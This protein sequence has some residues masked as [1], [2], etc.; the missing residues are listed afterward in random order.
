MSLTHFVSIDAS[1]TGSG[2]VPSSLSERLYM[3]HTSSGRRL[4]VPPF[5]RAGINAPPPHW[6]SY[7][8]SDGSDMGCSRWSNAINAAAAIFA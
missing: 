8:V 3:A 4:I 5:P 2:G 7:T 1:A 6:H